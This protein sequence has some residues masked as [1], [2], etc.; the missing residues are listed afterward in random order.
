MRPVAS[1]STSSSVDY[2]LSSRFDSA[3][4]VSVLYNNVVRSRSSGIQSS[5]F[6]TDEGVLLNLIRMHGVDVPDTLSYNEKQFLILRHLLL[7]DCIRHSDLSNSLFSSWKGNG[8]TDMKDPMLKKLL[9]MHWFWVNGAPCYDK[10][11]VA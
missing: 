10:C 2:Q 11:C 1:P 6:S 9:T 4:S 3:H 5:C 8:Y 7:G